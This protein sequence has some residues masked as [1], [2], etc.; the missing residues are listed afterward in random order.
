MFPAPTDAIK[1]V[2]PAFIRMKLW[3]KLVTRAGL[4]FLPLH[5]LRHTYASLLLQDRESPAYV[6][7]QLGHSSIQLT[8]D[9]YGHFIP[10]TNRA[11]VDRLAKI[12]TPEPSESASNHSNF[13]GTKTAT[14]LVE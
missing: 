11:A 12:T 4:R 1:P 9:R 14:T 3:Y 7:A 8:V 6:K 2:N 10:G 13:D 5:S